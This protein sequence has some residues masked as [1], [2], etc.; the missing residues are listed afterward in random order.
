MWAQI[1]GLKGTYV[2]SGTNRIGSLENFQ[3]LDALEA[4]VPVHSSL[5]MTIDDY[6]IL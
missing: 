3:S 6:S 2:P 4:S 1:L 5:K